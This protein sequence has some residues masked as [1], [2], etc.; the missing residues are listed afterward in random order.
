MAKPRQWYLQPLI[1]VI[2]CAPIFYLSDSP[3]YQYLQPGQAELKLAF[4]HAA[5]RKEECRSR[6][7]EELQKMAPNMR[8]AK[9]CSRER[10]DML[11]ELL[12]NGNVIATKVFPPPGLHR[13]GSAYVYAKFPLPVGNHLL[14]IRMRDSVRDE[15]FDYKAERDVSLVE[16][17]SLVV[18]FDGAANKFIFY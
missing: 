7:R 13:D 3:A 10:S 18:G 6:S 2:F 1:Y 4:K 5:Q 15:G 12:L 9:D 8:K 14:T 17:Q 11:V 16:G